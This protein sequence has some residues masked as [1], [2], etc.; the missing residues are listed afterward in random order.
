MKRQKLLFEIILGFGFAYYIVFNFFSGDRKFE[1]L[2]LGTETVSYFAVDER[3]RPIHIQKSNQEEADALLNG[4]KSRGSKPVI[5]FLG[6]SQT[7]SINQQKQGEVNFVEILY[8]YSLGSPLDVLCISLPNA[9]LQEF[10]LAYE[11]WKMKLPI[12]AVV[13]PVFMDDLREDGIRDVFFTDLIREKF[14]LKDTADFAAVKINRELQSY[15]PT[16]ENSKM[17]VQSE[18]APVLDETFQERTE[19]FLNRKLEGRSSTWGNRSNVRGEFFNWLYKLR[20]TV[21]GIKANTIRKMIPQRLQLNMHSLSLLVKECVKENKKV[22]LYIPPIR[23]DAKLPYDENEYAKFKDSVREITEVNKRLIYFKNFENI[24]PTELWGYKA[25]TN[26]QSEREV[27]YMHFQYKGHQIM[28][29]SLQHVLEKA[30]YP[31]GI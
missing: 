7:H 22:L 17:N 6:N 24:V 29:D 10:Y 11:Y 23:S 9:G 13:L 19:N 15:W 3:Q 30:I 18:D 12:Q 21:L 14:Q 8:K 31:H 26:L 16:N 25:A 5:L 1:D 2:A 27:D 4:W 20:N 28:A